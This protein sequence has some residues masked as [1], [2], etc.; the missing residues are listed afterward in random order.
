MFPLFINSYVIAV[1]EQKTDYA[2]KNNKMK[3]KEQ[4]HNFPLKQLNT[5]QN[6]IQGH[7]KH[8]NVLITKDLH[9]DQPE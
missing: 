1:T 2:Q 7:A 8:Y 4:T 6:C 9:L 3:K 5:V